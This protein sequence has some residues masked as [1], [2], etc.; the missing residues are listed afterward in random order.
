MSLDAT[1]S[2]E[3]KKM[4]KKLVLDIRVFKKCEPKEVESWSWKKMKNEKWLVHWG[5]RWSCKKL[6]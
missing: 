1:A 3:V 2:F 4:T 5:K 6:S